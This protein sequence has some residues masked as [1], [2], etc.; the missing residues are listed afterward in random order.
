MIAGPCDCS[1]GI[2]M[3]GSGGGIN[4]VAAAAAA[5]S[6]RNASS[7]AACNDPAEDAMCSGGRPSG[8]REEYAKVCGERGRESLQQASLRR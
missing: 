7:A 2:M 4:V 6:D 3:S 1:S 8:V 5:N